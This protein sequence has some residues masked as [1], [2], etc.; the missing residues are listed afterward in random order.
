MD[1]P[2]FSAHNPAYKRHVSPVDRDSSLYVPEYAKDKVL[3]CLNGT[4]ARRAGGWKTYMVAKDDNWQRVGAKSGVPVGVLKRVNDNKTL[5]AGMSLNVPGGA[6]PAAVLIAQ[7]TPAAAKKKETAPSP[8]SAARKGADSPARTIAAP[9][10]TPQASS[11]KSAQTKTMPAPKTEAKAA[12]KEENSYVVKA[13]DTVYSIA[14]TYGTDVDSVLRANQLASPQQL[15][16][17]QKIRI[18]GSSTGASQ[19]TATTKPNPPR[20]E[21]T[22]D[23]SKTGK[24]TSDVQI[25]LAANGTGNDETYR[26]QPGDTMWGIARKH[27]M[28]LQNLMRINKI[29]ESTMLRPGDTIKVVVQ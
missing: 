11:V 25:T 26:V 3:A 23:K 8:V 19:T 17:G 12:A 18:P 16:A 15:R 27:N 14:R 6:S 21:N 7:A 13:G 22:A 29:S 28:P 5:K 24:Q 20:Q 2:E 10:A 4:C 1:W 9:K